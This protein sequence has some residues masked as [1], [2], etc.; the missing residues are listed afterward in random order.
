MSCKYLTIADDVRSQILS[1][2]LRP[3]DRLPTEGELSARHGVSRGT[4]R[5]ALAELAD[6]G[7]IRSLQGSGS[8]V[9]STSPMSRYFSLSSFDEEMRALGHVPTTRVLA[10]EITTSP[11]HARRLRLSPHASLIRIRRLRLADNV[12]MALEERVM[13][14]TLCPGILDEDLEHQSLHWLIAI[15][16]RIPLARI[17]HVVDRQRAGPLIA[18][19]LQVAVGT[20]VLAIERLTYLQDRTGRRPAV[21]FTATHRDMPIERNEEA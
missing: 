9:A 7:L 8:Y 13:P 14:P 18:A 19:E 21:W 10:A 17:D 12:P 16:Y 3:L 11:I 5:R 20:P 2:T 4:V 6:E 15:K 1:G